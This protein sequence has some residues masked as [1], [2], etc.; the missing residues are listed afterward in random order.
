MRIDGPSNTQHLGAHSSPSNISSVFN[1]NQVTN[2]ISQLMSGKGNQTTLAGNFVGFGF[3]LVAAG[4]AAG[5]SYNDLENLTQAAQQLLADILLGSIS[6]KDIKSL[7]TMYT[8]VLSDVGTSSITQSMLNEVK[9]SSNIYNP[10]NLKNPPC[11]ANVFSGFQ[12]I[13]KLMQNS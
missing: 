9:D 3:A 5:C 2:I 10:A 4:S 11:Y 12:T 6:T 7:N 1:S 8:K 13:E